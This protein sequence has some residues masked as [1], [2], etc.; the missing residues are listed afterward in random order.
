MP[1]L[2]HKHL[3]YD[4][5][6]G[7]L[8]YDPTS[9][10]LI[11]AGEQDLKAIWT[12]RYQKKGTSTVS[13]A[14]AI[15]NM[16]ADAWTGNDGYFAAHF[17]LFSRWTFY[18]VALRFDTDATGDGGA[19]GQYYI[20]EGESASIVFVNVDTTAGVRPFRMGFATTASGTPVTDWSWVTNAPYMTGATSGMQRLEFT[21][22]TLERYF[23][24]FLYIDDAS[25]AQN[26]DTYELT[27]TSSAYGRIVG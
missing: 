7:R 21:S 2:G 4:P 10:H 20:P 17:Y 1:Y 13:K 25:A 14:D 23:W 18:M 24:I 8:I 15:A 5:T 27:Q 16:E 6:S 12:Q 19:L 26:D 22:L 9:G 3:I 11:K